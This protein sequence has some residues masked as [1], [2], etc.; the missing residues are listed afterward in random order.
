[1]KKVSRVGGVVLC[2][3]VVA[4]STAFARVTRTTFDF[5]FP[6]V[7]IDGNLDDFLGADGVVRATY[8]D[9]RDRLRIVGRAVVEN[10]S[11]RLQI[12]NDLGVLDGIDGDVV[13]DRYRVTKSGVAT[14]NG[15]VRDTSGEF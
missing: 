7:D 1:M 8:N 11:N 15:L 3:A 5:F 4:G 10:D 2:L 13:R 6:G 9:R 12:Y 14:Y